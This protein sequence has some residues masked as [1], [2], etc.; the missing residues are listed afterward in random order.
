MYQR[1]D[2]ATARQKAGFHWW[3]SGTQAALRQVT[4]T[5]IREFN[6]NANACIEAYKKGRPIL[7]EMFGEE[8]GLPTP[9]TPAVS[10]GHA[11]GLGSELLFPEGGE[12]AHTHIY[13][14]LADGIR[15]LKQRVDFATAGKAPFY[16]DFLKQMQRAF[17]DEKVGFS[18]GLEGPI[19]TAWELRGTDF[20]MD[21]FDQPET[22]KEFLWLST[23]SILQFHC[24]LCGVRGAPVIDPGGSYMADDIAAMVPPSHFAEFVIPFWDQYF[25]GK[26]TGRRSAHVEDLKPAQLKFLEEIGLSDYDPSISHKLNPKLVSAHCRVPYSWRLGSFHYAPLSVQEVEDF[27]YQSV[28][29]GANSVHSYVEE[30]LCSEPNITK[31]KAFI[32]AAKKAQQVLS[33]GATRED[34]GKLVSATGRAKFWEHWPE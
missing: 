15:A 11:N 5:P 29:D 24:F 7:R 4:Q 28:A 9:A 20:L 34:V 14:S 32:R 3:V 30:S 33:G 8:L 2:Y 13:S 12:V 6:L 1:P 18:Y 16:L 17:P 25:S 10:Y 27:V 19:T 22:A 21:I 31:V 26:T 23:D